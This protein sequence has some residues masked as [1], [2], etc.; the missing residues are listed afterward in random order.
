VIAHSRPSLG[1][2][3]AE[4]VRRVVASGMLAEGPEVEALESGLAALWQVPHACAVA[5][6]TAALHL[7][8]LALG[9]APGKRVLL[10]SY[11]CVSLL[12]AVAYTGA[13]PVLVDNLEGH[14]VPDLNEVGRRLDSR[15]A[16]ALLPH[17]FGARLD[18]GQ[19]PQEVN[20]L[21]DSTH[22][23]GIAGLQGR[24]TLASFFATKMLASGEGG[25]FLTDSQELDEFVR[26]HRSYDE[27]E[28]WR[29]RY[30]YKMTDMAAALL[31]VQ[32]G[33]LPQFLARRR[34]IAQRYAAHWQQHE[35]L[36]LPL[37][38]DHA[39][40][41]YRFV[42]AAQVPLQPLLDRL[43]ERGVGARRPVYRPLHRYLDLPDRDYPKATQWFEQCLSLPVYPSLSDDEVERVIGVVDEELA[44][45]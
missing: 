28:N 21:E 3:E 24:A 14:F 13:E 42:A 34:A 30:N 32:L 10:P 7:G 11:G 44:R 41:H 18:L 38:S 6:G 27:K 20:V 31:R 40:V 8:L 22:S 29:P 33:R 9:A 4:A 19:L 5:H 16:A 17:L 43:R 12:N 37:Q 45:A 39:H 15:V 23:V 25:V 1:A 35:R 36:R 26:D 2:E